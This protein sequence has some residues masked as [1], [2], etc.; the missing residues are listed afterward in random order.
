MHMKNLKNSIFFKVA[1]IVLITLMLLIPT[2][3]IEDLIGERETT[4]NNAIFEVSSKWGEAQT[5][6][7]PFIDRKSVV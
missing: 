7:G 3:M 1:T 6:S 4:Q 2:S 5:I